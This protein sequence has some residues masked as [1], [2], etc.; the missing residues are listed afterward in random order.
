MN[1]TF[2]SLMLAS[3]LFVQSC[4]AGALNPLASYVSLEGQIM[5]AEDI[6]AI[7]KKGEFLIIASDEAA[8]EGNH[9][10]YIQL[11][12]KASD[13]AY[14]VHH[15]ILL[16]EGNK[17]EGKEM[18]IEGIAVEGNTAYII[19]SHALK[20]RKLK[21]HKKYQ[22]NRRVFFDSS[23]KREKNRD[24][25]YRIEIDADGKVLKKDRITL[26]D[27]IGSDP[28][29]KT[30]SSIPS[31]ENGI[32]IEGI[33]VK[34]GDLYVGFRGPVF[35]GNY[36][37]VMR[38]KFDDAKHTYEILYVT[39]GGRGIRSITRVS[40]G[41]LILAGAVGDSDTSYQ[42]YHWDGKDVT[43]G[44]DRSA[45]SIG[46][47]RL[48][49]EI[50]PPQGGKAEGLTVLQEE[51]GLYQLMIVFDGV[52]DINKVMQYLLIPKP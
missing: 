18:D 50:R 46:K 10:N 35:R 29:L 13:G 42:L 3:F 20:R 11:L 22:K 40:D 37:P 48:L 9:K 21:E 14:H 45:E 34:D 7:A 52:K 16:L 44:K 8:G 24:Y 28:A 6:S 26:R 41:F 38:L 5:A 15:N 33:A 32:D 19:G 23:I 43:P 36:V 25:L 51:E 47:L 1:S 4:Y 27:I 39:L 30:F 12:K 31:K 17:K 49:V 2:V